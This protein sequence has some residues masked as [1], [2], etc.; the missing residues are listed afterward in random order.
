M[1]RNFIALPQTL[2]L[3]ITSACSTTR[4]EVFIREGT[5]NEGSDE[6]PVVAGLAIDGDRMMAIANLSKQSGA[7]PGRFAGGPG[8]DNK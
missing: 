1:Y 3:L 7:T 8:S 6:P 4:Y 2:I 5:V